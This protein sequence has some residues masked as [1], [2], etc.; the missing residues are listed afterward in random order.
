MNWSARWP[1]QM[2]TVLMVAPLS[3]P[4]GPSWT[5]SPTENLS[6]YSLRERALP[7]TYNAFPK[8][9][10][11]VLPAFRLCGPSKSFEGICPIIL[12]LPAVNPAKTKS[13]TIDRER[14]RNRRIPWHQHLHA[15][16]HAQARRIA[17]VQLT[18]NRIGYRRSQAKTA[19][20]HGD[21]AL[22]VPIWKFGF[23]NVSN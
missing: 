4:R 19:W 10:R 9:R 12:A 11:W 13:L 18:S 6:C 2:A 17:F 8:L 21:E 23:L 5:P 16:S 22:C 1:V 14:A 15:P 3:R 7:L 20:R